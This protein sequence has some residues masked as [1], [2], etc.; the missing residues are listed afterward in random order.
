LDIIESELGTQ[1]GVVNATRRDNHIPAAFVRLARDAH[2]RY[3]HMSPSELAKVIVSGARADM[4]ILPAA[5]FMKVM[6]RW[7]CIY[8]KAASAR[9]ASKGI[10]SGVK[11]RAVGQVIFS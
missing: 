5:Q 8:C 9:V 4:H 6:E 10:G 2:V 11:L 7:P 3:A 1:S